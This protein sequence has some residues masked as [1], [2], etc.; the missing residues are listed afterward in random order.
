MW[1]VRN[2]FLVYCS[3]QLSVEGLRGSLTC[4][5]CYRFYGFLEAVAL[6]S[7]D[8]PA[9]LDVFCE[10]GGSIFDSTKKN[11]CIFMEPSEPQP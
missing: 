9:V 8:K 5:Y 6:L 2:L 4:Q 11:A 1:I 7:C 3:F 10:I